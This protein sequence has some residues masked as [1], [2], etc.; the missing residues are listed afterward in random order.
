M[1]RRANGASVAE[2]NLEAGR[3][4][5]YRFFVNGVTW[6]VDPK[7]DRNAIHLYGGENS[8]VIT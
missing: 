6:I 5:Q 8:V 4:Y 2:V 7:A 1:I 3:E